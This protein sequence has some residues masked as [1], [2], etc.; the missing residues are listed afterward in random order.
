MLSIAVCSAVSISSSRRSLSCSEI[1]RLI[2]SPLPSSSQPLQALGVGP[3]EVN[4]LWSSQALVIVKPHPDGLVVCA[5]IEFDFTVPGKVHFTINRHIENVSERR[6]R[7][8]L[9]RGKEIAEFGFR[10]KP[11]NVASYLSPK[12]V[13]IYRVVCREDGHDQ[14]LLARVQN[15]RFHHVSARDM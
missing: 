6:H 5:G 8:Q 1:S 9:A 10:R 7:T 13:Q 14:P 12:D 3:R 2:T 15:D 11:Q 4:H